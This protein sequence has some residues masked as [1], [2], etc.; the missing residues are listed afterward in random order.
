MQ[1]QVGEEKWEKGKRKKER[2]IRRQEN[3]QE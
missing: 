2:K 3:K 1:F